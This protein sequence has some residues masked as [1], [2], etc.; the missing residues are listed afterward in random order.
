VRRWV[1]EE[2]PVSIDVSRR[3]EQLVRAK[4]GQQMKRV[5]SFYLEMVTSLSDSAIRG[6]LLTMDLSEMR[7][8]DQ[9]SRAALPTPRPLECQFLDVAE[10]AD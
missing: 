7:L 9:L 6:R 5:H 2:R 4:H 8:D 10:A 3:I 1:A